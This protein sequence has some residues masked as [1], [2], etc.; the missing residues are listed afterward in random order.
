MRHGEVNELVNVRAG[1]QTRGYKTQAGLG[2]CYRS[3]SSRDGAGPGQ[4]TALEKPSLVLQ[5]SVGDIKHPIFRF[6]VIQALG[7]C[8]LQVVPV[9]LCGIG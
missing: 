9:P 5:C 7:Q 4:D 1:T 2:P 8:D 3:P 6:Q